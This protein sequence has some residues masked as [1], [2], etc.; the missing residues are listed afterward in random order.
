[1]SSTSI[2]RRNMTRNIL[3]TFQ[4]ECPAWLCGADICQPARSPHPLYERRGEERQAGSVIT[5]TT[6]WS[7]VWSWHQADTGIQWHN[8][9]SPL[10]ITPGSWGDGSLG[11]TSQC[12]A[13]VAGC[14][15]QGC[16]HSLSRREERP[17]LWHHGPGS[18][19]QS[20]WDYLAGTE[21]QIGGRGRVWWM[22]PVELHNSVQLWPGSITGQWGSPVLCGYDGATRG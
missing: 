11:Q 4:P 10:Y 7:C 22:E 16:Q 17:A 8:V 18:H 14:L 2:C 1:M 13:R 21:H 12:Q 9:L 20:C 19:S 3:T 6:D 15:C 5:T